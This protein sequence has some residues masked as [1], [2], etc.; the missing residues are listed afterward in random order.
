MGMRA[1]HDGPVAPQ[2]WSRS[3]R[4]TSE[5]FVSNVIGVGPDGEYA[6]I[7]G[8]CAHCGRAMFPLRDM[9]MHC[10]VP[11]PDPMPFDGDGVVYSY[12]VIRQAAPGFSVPYVLASVD[13][14][15]GVRIIGQVKAQP[16]DVTIG[17]A[18]QLKVE[19][20]GEDSRGRRVIG[21]RFHVSEEG[22]A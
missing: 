19:P 20:I 12:T 17:T 13:L 7:G 10:Q 9:C 2:G 4:G 16:A 3:P 1:M 8:Q 6:L 22:R 14:A 15:A 18:V 11:D 5:V 21:Y